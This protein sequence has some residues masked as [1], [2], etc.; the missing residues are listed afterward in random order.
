MYSS[1]LP[2]L[3][4][5]A[6]TQFSIL[7]NLAQ[8]RLTFMQMNS[9]MDEGAILAQHD[10]KIK[11]YHTTNSLIRELCVYGPAW[12]S[13]K[14]AEYL[15]GT[16]IGKLQEGQATYSKMILNADYIANPDDSIAITISKIKA[17]G[18]L[19]FKAELFNLAYDIKC[20]GAK[21]AT[22]VLNNKWLR[23]KM[24]DGEIVPI[25]VQKAGGKRMH[26]NNFMNGYR[27]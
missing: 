5:P 8:F 18:S 1:K 4:D 23:I 21:N 22:Q 3:R 20:F 27:K 16:L 6:P 26:I 24:Q 15:N 17:F 25:F 12:I 2:E 14:L 10:F 9:K 11:R 19:L 13:N 7:N